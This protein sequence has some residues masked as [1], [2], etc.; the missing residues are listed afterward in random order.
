VIRQ[1]IGPVLLALLVLC[2]LGSAFASGAGAA[3]LADDSGA[4]WRLEQPAPPPPPTGVEAAG[5]PVGLGR[6]GDIEFFSPNRGALITAGNGSTVSAGVW[7]YNG[8]G[9]HELANK[10]GA[11]DG[12]IAWAGPDEFWTVSD[13]RP[14][15]A[16]NSKGEQPPLEDDTLCHFALSPNGQELEVKASYASLAF[17]STS[18]Q[19]MHAAACLT[20]EDCWFGGDALGEPAI[21]SFQLHWNGHTVAAEPYL[22]EGHAVEGM[23][24]FDGDIYE[25]V[26]L[27]SSD[28]A[29]KRS[30][31]LPALHLIDGEGLVEPIVG[32]PL[33][34]PGESP[35]GLDYLRLSASEDALWAAAGSEPKPPEKSAPAGVTV[36]RYSQRQYSREA[37]AYEEEATPT[38][39]QVIGPEPDA[40]SGLEE[41]PEEVVGSIA[42]EP[43]TDSAWISLVPQ[44]EAG[45]PSPLA[46]ADL[47]RVSAD[48]S[49]SDKLELPV[50]K[51]PVEHIACPAVHDCWATTVGGWLLHLSTEEE[52]EHPALNTELAFSGGYLI[53]ERPLDEGVP[54]ETP[55]T[56]PVDDSGLEEGQPPQSNAPIKALAPNIFASVA[57]PLLSNIHTKLIHRTTLVLSFHLAVKATVRLL[58]KR[59]ASVVASTPTRTLGA[60]NRS[61]Q[62]HLN[63]HRWPTKLEL[64]THA[65]APLPTR[66]TRE[67]GTNTVST[68]LAF[69][70]ALGPLGLGLGY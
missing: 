25:S 30:L 50:A 13:G 15:Q 42:A 44:E 54:Q 66:S 39:Q 38:W 9:W 7:L 58:A 16:A 12:R 64:H 32:L 26:R 33:Y 52:L 41:F 53:T 18:Y 22:P 21:G 24:A 61:L 69:P 4:E 36:L 40:T 20:S 2:L 10:C 47:A 5:V 14:G 35:Y 8:G 29:I 37:H 56:L 49:V 28:R 68:S 60:G 27:S 59:H 23:T 17:Q 3:G 34:G 67:A 57:V 19:P 63:L 43:A 1:R 51:G 48:G 6:I 31:E 62:L 55:D 46:H 45:E 11:T 65:L 70:N